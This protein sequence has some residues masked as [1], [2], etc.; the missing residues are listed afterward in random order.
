MR[1]ALRRMGNSTGFI[2][3]KPILVEAGIGIGADLEISVE[4]GRIIAAPVAPGLRAG[5]EASAR[6][7]AASGDDSLVWPDFANDDDSALEW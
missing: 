7:I 4:G 5:W 1:T 2:V 6:D 3:P